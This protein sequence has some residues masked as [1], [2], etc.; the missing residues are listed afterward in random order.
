[1]DKGVEGIVS[2]LRDAPYWPNSRPEWL[3]KK[4]C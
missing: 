1:M 2:K 3:E 4:L